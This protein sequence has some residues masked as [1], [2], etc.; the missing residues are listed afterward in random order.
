MSETYLMFFFWNMLISQKSTIFD[1]EVVNIDTGDF[2]FV[3]KGHVRGV[4]TIITARV[5]IVKV[6][7]CGTG[8]ECDLSVDNRDGI[9]K[10]HIIHAI[11]TID[12]RFRKLSFL[13]INIP[14]SC[15]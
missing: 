8:I 4:Q 1:D 7:D 3:G 13:V 5:P 12:E 10:S 6:T 9:V 14:L 15:Q 2:C 11:S